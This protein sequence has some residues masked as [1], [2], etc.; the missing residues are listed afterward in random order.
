MQDIS[1]SEK[2]GGLIGSILVGYANGFKIIF[3]NLSATLCILGIF[4]RIWE[5]AT[6]S[7]YMTKYFE[8]Y[9]SKGYTTQYSVY[10][11]VAILIGSFAS[12]IFSLVLIGIL[13]EDNPMT[14]PYV[15]IA[16]H[17]IDIPALGFM[18]LIQDNFWWSVSGF[19]I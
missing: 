7:S 8:I 11:M 15:C 18:F 19:F 12:N 3:S 2:Q 17:A 5:T 13:K 1:K 10:T 16:R 4:C 14:I 6:S 9:L